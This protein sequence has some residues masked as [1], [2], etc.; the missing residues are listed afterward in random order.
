MTKILKKNLND[1]YDDYAHHPTEI[2]SILEGVKTYMKE[3]IIAVFNHI[4]TQECYLLKNCKIISKSSLVLLCP[5]YAAGEKKNSRFNQ[6]NFAKLISKMS[7]TQVI[8]IKNYKELGK[9]FKRNLISDEIIIGMGAGVISKHMRE[10]K[11]IL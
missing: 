8:I 3:K 10:L 4:V 2:S 6:L 1:F 11:T 5:L 7:K 9:Y